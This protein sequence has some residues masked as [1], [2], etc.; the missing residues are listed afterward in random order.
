MPQRC[1]P[2]GNTGANNN[3]AG[4]TGHDLNGEGLSN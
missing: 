2:Q 4:N 3:G 1:G